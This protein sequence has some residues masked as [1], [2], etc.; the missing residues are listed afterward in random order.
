MKL[1]EELL[2]VCMCVCVCVSVCERLT[3]REKTKIIRV[4][5][6]VCHCKIK[7]HFL[8]SVCRQRWNVAQYGHSSD[9]KPYFSITPTFFF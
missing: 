3:G 8:S 5:S 4:L 2:R 1:S 6:L 9:W 7:H